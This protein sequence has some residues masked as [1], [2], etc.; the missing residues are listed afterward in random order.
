MPLPGEQIALHVFEP[1]YQR[2][3]RELETNDLEEF[4]IVY[5]TRANPASLELPLRRNHAVGI[6]HGAGG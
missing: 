5:Q 6:C 1:R 2:L 3:F 4:G